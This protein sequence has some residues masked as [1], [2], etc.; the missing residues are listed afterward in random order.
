MES[1]VFT[2][3]GGEALYMQLYKHLV[4]EISTGRL[5]SGEKLPSKRRLAQDFA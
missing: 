4:N 5:K 3:C 2:P 1:A